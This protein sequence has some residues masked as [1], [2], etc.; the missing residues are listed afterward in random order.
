MNVEPTGQLRERKR[1]N[2]HAKRKEGKTGRKNTQER[3]S[4]DEVSQV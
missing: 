2:K 4:K 1:S 3:V